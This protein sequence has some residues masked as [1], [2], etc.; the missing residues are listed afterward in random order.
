MSRD[1]CPKVICSFSEAVLAAS[2]LVLVARVGRE[3]ERERRHVRLTTYLFDGPVPGTVPVPFCV[4]FL[5]LSRAPCRS[6][7]SWVEFLKVHIQAGCRMK[8][9]N[10]NAPLTK[11]PIR[12]MHG[13]LFTLLRESLPK[14]RYLHLVDHLF[15]TQKKCCLDQYRARCGAYLMK[16]MRSRDNNNKL[17]I[18]TIIIVLIYG[19][20]TL[21]WKV[22]IFT[23]T[24]IYPMIDLLSG[25]ILHHRRRG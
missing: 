11:G 21:A 4:L 18:K 17:I 14:V 25:M 19:W 23:S 8:G 10:E 22:V 20:T 12:G 24:C 7:L 16:Q 2:F 5:F 13:D 3:R 9:T 15:L 1:L 6:D